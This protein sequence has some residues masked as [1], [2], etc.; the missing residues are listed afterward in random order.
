MLGSRGGSLASEEAFR[1]LQWW[2]DSLLFRSNT[3][4]TGPERT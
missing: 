3:N 2:Q 4:F 1:V